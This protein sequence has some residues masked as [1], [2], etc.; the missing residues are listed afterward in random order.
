MTAPVPPLT[1]FDRAARRTAAA[2][3]DT[4]STSFGWACRL[5]G[6]SVRDHVRAVYALV[7]VAD[8]IV[9]DVA[10]DLTVAERDELLT[11]LEEEVSSATKRGYSHHLVVHGFVRT[12][13]QFG[14]G[15]D[16]VDPFFASMRTDLSV[17]EH[18]AESFARY[19]HGSAEVVGLMCLRIFV[20]GA[21]GAYARRAA[22]AARLGA[23]F[24]KVNFLRDLADDVDVRGRRYFPGLDPAAFDDATK[25]RLLD[26]I[27]AD[28]AVA[29]RAIR[30]LPRS[31]RVAVQ[32]A[33]DLFAELARRLR[34]TPA[35]ALRHER[36]R[37]PDPVKARLVARALAR[38]AVR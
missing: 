24:Q 26:D 22:G 32:L 38:E 17:T 5:L 1:D 37:V 12:A 4:Y 18:D 23:A 28:L 29:Q 19:V 31:S 35:A 10:A 36:V 15:A 2:V 20:D 8:E 30:D 14:I 6:P 27:E 16:L 34:D 25:D 21:D 11:G 9:D 33:H 3:V 13:R 7:R